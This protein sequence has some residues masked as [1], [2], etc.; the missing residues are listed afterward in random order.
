MTKRDTSK[1]YFAVQCENCRK[2]I[3]LAEDIH[4][5]RKKFI[6]HPQTALKCEGCDHVADYPGSAILLGKL[7]NLQ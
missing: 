7:H 2:M 6:G 1:L 5:G 4:D 3:I